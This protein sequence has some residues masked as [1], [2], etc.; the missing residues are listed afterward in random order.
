MPAMA[1]LDRDG[2]AARRDFV[3]GFLM[4]CL[5][6][7]YRMPSTEEAAA[8]FAEGRDLEQALADWG[9]SN[10]YPPEPTPPAKLARSL[11]A[12]RRR[13]TDAVRGMSGRATRPPPSG[14]EG[15]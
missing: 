13:L 11:A 3:S 9:A 12:G 10:P 4:G 5:T 7:G 14:K 1:K 15:A 8:R 6:R 2:Y